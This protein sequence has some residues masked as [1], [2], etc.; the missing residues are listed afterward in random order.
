MTTLAQD[1]RSAAKPN[2]E[3][4]ARHLGRW[5]VRGRLLASLLMA[6]VA[7]G[8]A[9]PPLNPY[10][11]DTPPLIVVPVA[12]AGVQD[13]RARFREIFCAV[14]EARKAELPDYRTC[15]E[16][17]TRVGVEPAGTAAS[18]NLA[19]S[20]RRLVA[21]LVAGFG[22][23]CFA[24]WLE[25]PGTTVEHLRRQGYELSLIGV[26]GLSSTTR[27]ARLIRDAL[28]ALPTESGPP[29]IV[30]VGYSKGSNDILEALVA[31]PEV[32]PRVAAFVSM[33]GTIG[34]SPL[35]NDSD[36]GMAELLTRFP[37]S[38]CTVGDRGAVASLRPETRQAWLAANPLPKELRYYSVVTFPQPE[39]ISSI[40][41]Q[42]Y[43]KLGRV[44][45]R[46]DSQAI[47]YDQVVPGSTLVAY[48]NADHWA[49]AV[50]I[51]RTHT[52]IAAMFVTQN[53]Y[54]REALAEA[55]LR[56]VEEDLELSQ[57]PGAQSTARP[58]STSASAPPAE[59]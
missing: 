28:M 43:D 41:R 49:V 26:E 56:F 4:R 2:S 55:V 52:T 57:R 40:L 24:N 39:R 9:S 10:S 30:L 58:T 18:V 6:G 29:R 21:V 12:Q 46:N 3:T 48:L 47:F 20:R 45:A 11:V 54:P 33:A 23:D 22:Y 1:P 5:C 16:A 19:P 51:A 36:Q 50:P 34:G 37:G 17:L 25:A 53:A 13:K 42:G 32:R 8:C 31:Y 27:N 59:K 7:A 14:L 38:K 35:A 15:D 44:D